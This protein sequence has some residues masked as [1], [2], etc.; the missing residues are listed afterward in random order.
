M[1]LDQL[2]QGEKVHRK[3]V[4]VAHRTKGIAEQLVLRWVGARAAPELASQKLLLLADQH[5][6]AIYSSGS[7]S[8]PD[9]NSCPGAQGITE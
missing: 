4:G 6:P 5:Q 7:P 3:D 1:D 9:S 2:K 8:A